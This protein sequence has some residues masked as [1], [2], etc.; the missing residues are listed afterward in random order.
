MHIN[1]HCAITSGFDWSERTLGV[2]CAGDPTGYQL[3]WV[4]SAST[5]SSPQFLPDALPTTTLPIYPRLEQAQNM[6]ACI[7]HGLVLAYP[8]AWKDNEK[9]QKN[10][11]AVLPAQKGTVATQKLHG[12]LDQAK[13]NVLQQKHITN[14]FI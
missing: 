1:L 8:T 13:I 7:P 4:S 12:G 6:L 2:I 11:L 5:P 3:I 9:K 10:Q 14:V